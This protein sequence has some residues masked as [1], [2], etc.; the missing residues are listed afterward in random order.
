MR[1]LAT[2]LR[3]QR[4]TV[5]VVPDDLD[6]AGLLRQGLMALL[7]RRD[8][9]IDPLNGVWQAAAHT[10]PD[11][12]HQRQSEAAAFFD[13]WAPMAR[14][15][16]LD[17]RPPGRDDRVLLVM[18][19]LGA[20]LRDAGN[21]PA[22]AAWLQALAQ[23]F[24]ALDGRDRRPVQVLLAIDA[25]SLPLLELVRMQGLPVDDLLVHWPPDGQT[26]AAAA[27][28]PGAPRQGAAAAP[29][30][31]AATTVPAP[32]QPWPAM[33]PAPAWALGLLGLAAT[34][35]L[36]WN[37]TGGRVAAASPPKTAVVLAQAGTPAPAAPT[38]VPVANATASAWPLMVAA[39]P[40]GLPQPVADLAGRVGPAAGVWLAP[41]MTGD[42]AEGLQRLRHGPGLL[43]VR[44]DALR[45]AREADPAL[46]PRLLTPLYTEP[47]LAIVRSSSSLVSLHQVRG[48]RVRVAG[49]GSADAL[50]ARG[51]LQAM[52]GADAPAL[53]HAAEGAPPL[54]PQADDEVLLTVG[55]PGRPWTDAVPPGLADQYRLLPLVATDPA[56]Q[57][58]LRQHLPL[59]V[60]GPGGRQP[61]PGLVSFLVA[62]PGAGDEDAL[63]RLAQ[64]LCRTLPALQ[65]GGDPAW[66]GWQ[67]GQVL[68]SGWPLVDSAAEAWRA[69][70]ATPPTA[71]GTLVADAGPDRPDLPSHSA[72][73]GPR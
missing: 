13:G 29:P 10:V 18:P 47:L 23:G 7:G 26:V 19:Q 33:R 31:L 73:K 14:S 16:A 68:T 56:G 61:T 65:Q 5:L 38:A 8:S 72:P 58:A 52:F 36:A 55:R 53:L 24:W 46:A 11:R 9:D 20:A 6:I 71:D 22:A 64:A 4:L 54:L 66:R 28:Q 27:A 34:G 32:A 25:G 40:G 67:P 2:H 37:L 44:Y 62:S 12:R 45:A 59:S 49:A 69:C 35:L 51:L 43:V 50:S 42:W 15:G 60:D 17:W 70:P 21:D 3:A 48:Q 57:R 30:T 63:Q 1:W 41:Q 39:S